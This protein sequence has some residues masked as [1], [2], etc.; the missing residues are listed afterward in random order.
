MRNNNQPGGGSVSDSYK[1]A[2]NASMVEN[3]TVYVIAVSIF[4]IGLS[5][6]S[7]YCVLLIIF[8]LLPSLVAIVIDQGKERYISKIVGLYNTVGVATYLVKILQSSMPD[9]IAINIIIDPHSWLI[10]F[11]SAALGWLVYWLFPIVASYLYN[12]KINSRISELELELQEI[13]TEWSN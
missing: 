12:L 7:V 2:K 1:K 3:G 11:S 6:V 5:V 9:M 4:A 13:S 8:G 10:I